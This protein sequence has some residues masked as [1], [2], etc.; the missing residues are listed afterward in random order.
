MPRPILATISTEAMAYNLA[1]V[2]SRIQQVQQS[3]LAYAHRQ[4][5][6]IA[7]IKANAYGHGTLNAIKGFAQADALGMIDLADAVLCRENGWDKPIL[8][9]EGFF[10]ASDIPLLQHYQLTT[11]IHHDEQ[12]AL[13]SEAK[14]VGK[15]ID[16]MVKFNTGMNRLGFH[17]SRASHVLDQ[18]HQLQKNNIVGRIG[19]MTH[20]ANA[21]LCHDA[22]DESLAQMNRIKDLFG[23]RVSVCNS[24]ASLRYPEFALVGTENWIRPGICLY[25][26]TPFQTD[27]EGIPDV[28]F[29]PVMTLTARVLAVQSIQK[30]ASIGYGSTFTATEAMRIAVVACGYADG[31]PRSA[32]LGTPVTV[33]GI[34]SR[35]IGR[36]SMD[37]LTVDIT[38]IPNAGVHSKVVLWGEG[39]PSIDQVA[40]SAGRIGYELM[41]NLAKRVPLQIVE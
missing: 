34:D 10:D 14:A 37:M 16:V 8:L 27:K 29:K 21:D 26:S 17:I 20:F 33:D 19:C 7:V 1:Q 32:K 31:Y 36:V 18:L 15:P 3:S 6:T 30:G 9:L 23:N 22:V 35:I 11:A 24:A 2:K 41:C 5:M 28:V 4:V 12:V 40:D 13:L 39:G 38:H 25:G